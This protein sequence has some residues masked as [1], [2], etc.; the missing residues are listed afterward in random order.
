MKILKWSIVA[1]AVSINFVSAADGDKP[2]RVAAKG[3]GQ[4]GSVLVNPYKNAPLTA[5]IDLAGNHI[6]SVKVTVKGKGKDGVDINYNVEP[7][8]ILT[9]NGI[10]VIGLYPDFNNTVEVSYRKEGKLINETY[11]IVT[12]GKKSVTADKF[13]RSW[14]EITPQKVS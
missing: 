1:F 7:D 10:P 3:Q 9:H 5:I 2:H 13:V 11:R 4:I 14:P 6:D 12:S 8:S